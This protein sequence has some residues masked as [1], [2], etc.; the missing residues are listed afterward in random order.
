MT[1][2][3]PRL[4]KKI[5]VLTPPRVQ[6]LLVACA[7][8]TEMLVP[9]N[10]LVTYKHSLKQAVGRGVILQHILGGPFDPQTFISGLPFAAVECKNPATLC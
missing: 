6:A 8:L 3:S 1:L 4:R 10:G 2:T 9:G 5:F 7:R